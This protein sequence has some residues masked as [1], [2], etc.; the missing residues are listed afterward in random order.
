MTDS[1]ID[2]ERFVTFYGAHFEN[3]NGF[4]IFT[5]FLCVR[6][7]FKKCTKSSDDL[8]NKCV[9]TY[10]QWNRWGSLMYHTQSKH[11]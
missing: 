2:S 7:I 8:H 6:I 3:K 9:H 1:V 4:P 5:T 11:A 10:G